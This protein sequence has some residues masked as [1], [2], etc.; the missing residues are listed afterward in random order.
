M[1][2]ERITGDG[3]SLPIRKS[4][5]K[6]VETDPKTAN[7]EET[8]RGGFQ[9]YDEV[10]IKTKIQEHAQRGIDLDGDGVIS[11]REVLLHAVATGES[12]TSGLT[13][14]LD[15]EGAKATA[16]KVTKILDEQGSET[17]DTFKN[18]SQLLG[19]LGISRSNAEALIGK[20][21][22]ESDLDVQA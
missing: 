3:Q 19:T 20:V 8:E 18:T 4:N 10:K 12:K 22:S 7:T 13:S 9:S 15:I 16:E 1:S 14:G 6:K 21:K 2:I 5:P 11:Q 17:G